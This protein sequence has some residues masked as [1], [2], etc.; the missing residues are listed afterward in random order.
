MVKRKKKSKKKLYQRKFRLDIRKRFF[1]EWSVTGP[2]YRK[3]LM[4]SSLSDFKEH[5]PNALNH[6]V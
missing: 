6:M 5:L 4:A 2:G 1:T 3:V